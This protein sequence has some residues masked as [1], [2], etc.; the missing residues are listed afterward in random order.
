MASLAYDFTRDIGFSFGFWLQRRRKYAETGD[1]FARLMASALFKSELSRL[2][3]FA[4]QIPRPL[5]AFSIRE[6]MECGA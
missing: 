2:R 6:G 5:L 3:K 1:D 4:P